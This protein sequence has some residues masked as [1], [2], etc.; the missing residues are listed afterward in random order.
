MSSAARARRN[1]FAA[2]TLDR[3]AEFRQDERW[4]EAMRQKPECRF[5]LVDAGGC[6]LATADG[7]APQLLT[8]AQAEAHPA[9]SEAGFLGLAGEQPIFS[10]RLESHGEDVT[11]AASSAQWLDLRQVAERF[12]AAMASLCAYACGL[13]HWQARTRFC[14]TCGATLE[15][16]DGGHRA[17]CPACHAQFFPRLDPAIIVIVE[18]DGA[19]LL[20]RQARWPEGRFSTLA[21]FVEV[22]ETLADAVRR[23][24][25]E[26]AG[27]EVTDCDYYA[28]Q[29][30]PFPSSLMLGFTAKAAGRE[31]TLRDGELAQARWFTP[32][33]IVAGCRDGWL[34]LSS[35]HSISWHL[36]DRWMRQCGGISLRDIAD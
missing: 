7:S 19:C 29:P 22:G 27:I 24:V 33:E 8:L 31:L 30:W 36:L 28:S 16:K 3:A 5:V 32:E 12:S 18:H 25:Y 34:T 13:A 2:G 21:G 4:L 15:R 17:Q 1:A 10:L 14:A 23:E 11:E 20:G 26:E 35:P 9:G 6:L